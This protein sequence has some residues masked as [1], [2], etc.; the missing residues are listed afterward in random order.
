MNYICRRTVGPRPLTDLSL[1]LRFLLLDSDH[2]LQLRRLC[3]LRRAQVIKAVHVFWPSAAQE[4]RALLKHRGD[5]LFH[6]RGLGN[7]AN[8]TVPCR[9]RRFLFALFDALNATQQMTRAKM[10]H[11]EQQTPQTLTGTVNS[12]QTHVSHPAVKTCF[13][14]GMRITE[15]SQFIFT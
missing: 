8:H 14:E 3:L 13:I 11:V 1:E 12:V 10:F 4:L 5:L 7:S 2:A 15:N 9:R 6:R